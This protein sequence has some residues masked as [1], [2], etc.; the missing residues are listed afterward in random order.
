VPTGT[1]RYPEIVAVEAENGTGCDPERPAF[2]P[3]FH[4]AVELIGKRWTGAILWA[5][6]LRP[7]YFTELKK[8]A[9]GLSDRLLS[10][11]LRELEAAGIVERVVH[12]EEVPARV[13][14]RL[15]A[16]GE[17]LTPAMNALQDW[18]KRWHLAH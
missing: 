8:T 7:H 2:C 6:V 10:C 5:L 12:H 4:A 1:F 15:T 18:A 9:P 17:Q 13:S 11:R 16:K 14:Y 3:D